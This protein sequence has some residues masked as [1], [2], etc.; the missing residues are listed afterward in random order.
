MNRRTLGLLTVLAAALSLGASKAPPARYL[1]V[2]SHLAED[3]QV[4]IDG[5][6]PFTTPGYGSAV[7]K[8]LGGQRSL[9]VTSGQGVNY[10]GVLTLK[11]AELMR[12][13]GKAYCA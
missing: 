9:R 4:R 10:T 3:A 2:S 11:D 12:Y 6:K 7:V 1:H 13:Q 8:V 5:G